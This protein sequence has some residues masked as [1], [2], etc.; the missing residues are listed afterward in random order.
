MEL[1]AHCM[2]LEELI[3]DNTQGL[4]AWC[5]CCVRERTGFRTDLLGM[6]RLRK[7]IYREGQVV[8]VC[9]YM[10]IYVIYQV[11]RPRCEIRG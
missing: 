3:S 1:E 6:I 5:Y 11:D 4:A 2:D 10:N 9:V 7:G 8:C